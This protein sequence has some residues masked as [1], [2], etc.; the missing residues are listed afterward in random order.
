[1]QKTSSYKIDRFAFAGSFGK[2]TNV[3]QSDADCIY[4]INDHEPPF[5]EIIKEFYDIC[6]HSAVRNSFE[7]YNIEMNKNSINLEIDG[8]EM[9]VVLATNFVTVKKKQSLAHIQQREALQRI[10]LNPEENCYKYSSAMAEATVNFMKHRVG[11]ANEMARIAKYWFKS[12]GIDDTKHISGASTFIELVA[13]YAARKGRRRNRQHNPY[14]KAF[15][16][17]LQM[18]MNFKELD[19]SFNNR[20]ALFMKHSFYHK[21]P[22]VIDPVNPYQ[23]FARYWSSHKDKTDEL[24]NEA[25]TT[26]RRLQNLVLNPCTEIDLIDA[27]FHN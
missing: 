16:R 3:L 20:S 13:V 23:N 26:F 6:N 22:R 9:D 14:L 12:R 4:F 17:F 7:S 27:L 18:L 5:D 1:M 21:M 19:V 24:K 15:I 25:A 10:K 2:R 11:F 8:L